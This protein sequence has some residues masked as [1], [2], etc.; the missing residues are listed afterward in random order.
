MARRARRRLSALAVH[1]GASAGEQAAWQNVDRSAPEDPSI[2]TD[3]SCW[4]PAELMRRVTALGA[5]DAQL[6][7]ALSATDTMPAL[8]SIIRE[9][10]PPSPAGL[11]LDELTVHPSPTVVDEMVERLERYGVVI[12]AGLVPPEELAVI[13][14]QLTSCGAF[15]RLREDVQL[16]ATGERMGQDVLVKAPAVHSLLSN[17]TVIAA[18]EDLLCRSSRKIALKL[19]EVFRIP[20]A[21]RTTNGELIPRGREQLLHREDLFWPFHHQPH[22]WCLDMLWSIDEFNEDNGARTAALRLGVCLSARGCWLCAFSASDRLPLSILCRKH[23]GRAVL[24][25]VA[26]QGGERATRPR[27]SS[28]HAQ[29]IGTFVHVSPTLQFHRVFCC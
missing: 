24:T 23:L 16:Q 8:L 26:P 9:L 21:G 11:T 7:T 2:D 4:Q 20:P 28:T 25:R 15:G 12:V 18:A 1:L 14:D 10:E 13:D 6:D 5:S 3:P 29:G 17:S 19:L 27:H 22:H